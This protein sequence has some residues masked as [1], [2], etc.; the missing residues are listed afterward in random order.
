LAGVGARLV[1][2]VIASISLYLS[3]SVALL[4]REEEGFFKGLRTFSLTP[5]PASRC[6]YVHI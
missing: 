5:T 4:F 3:L 6:A 1:V 2:V